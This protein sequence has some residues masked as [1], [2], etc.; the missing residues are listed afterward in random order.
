VTPE[1]AGGSEFAKLVTDHVFC[2]EQR[3]VTPSV[4][5][6]NGQPKHIGH[7]RRCARPRSYHGLAVALTSLVNLLRKFLLHERTFF[8]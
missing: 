1:G 7:D 5:D 6:S 2:D 3:D 8:N 4:M